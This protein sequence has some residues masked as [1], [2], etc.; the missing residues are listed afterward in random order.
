MGQF[1]IGDIFI[2]LSSWLLDD[3]LF[4]SNRKKSWKGQ[5]REGGGGR[6]LGY[7]G[8]GGVGSEE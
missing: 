3:I 1:R 8:G 5:I 7:Q 6:E 4:C 2:M